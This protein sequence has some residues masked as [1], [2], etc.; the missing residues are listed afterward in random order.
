MLCLVLKVTVL[1]LQRCVWSQSHTGTWRHHQP[2]LRWHHHSSETKAGTYNRSSKWRWSDITTR[3]WNGEWHCAWSP[4]LSGGIFLSLSPPLIYRL[5]NQDRDWP[6]LGSRGGRSVSVPGWQRFP[7]CRGS[8]GQ[9]PLGPW[10]ESNLLVELEESHAHFKEFGMLTSLPSMVRLF[11][12]F[13][14]V[15]PAAPK[16]EMI[17]AS[18]GFPLSRFLYR[19]RSSI[20]ELG[21]EEDNKREG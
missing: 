14:V 1:T 20:P 5:S 12:Y 21:R 15:F 19:V 4:A 3:Q 16:E 9:A 10:W 8:R 17:R 2:L 7:L 13:A 6:G 11:V 18:E